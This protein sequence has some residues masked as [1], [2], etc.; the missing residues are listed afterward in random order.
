[1]NKIAKIAV[2]IALVGVAIKSKRKKYISLT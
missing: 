2:I 1:M